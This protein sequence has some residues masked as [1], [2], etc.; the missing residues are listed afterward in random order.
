MS[1]IQDAPTYTAELVLAA[2]ESAYGVIDPTGR[3]TLLVE[4]S[5]ELESCDSDDF[6]LDTEVGE[7]RIM[8]ES[9]MES[10]WDDSLESYLEDCV[11][12]QLPEMARNY[13]DDKAWKRDARFD[14]WGHALNH[15]DGSGF[16]VRVAVANRI[17][18]V[19]FVRT[20]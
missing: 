19:Y 17:E 10:A 18:W 3:L 13:F 11:Y 12:P 2:I 8:S 20:N 15:Y 4:L 14:G 7:F 1:L 16:E 6:T 9:G 5:D